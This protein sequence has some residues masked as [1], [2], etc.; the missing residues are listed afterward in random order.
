MHQK[1]NGCIR[2]YLLLIFI[3]EAVRAGEHCRQP[4]REG[5]A[6]GPRTPWGFGEGWTQRQM[7]HI[8]Q[9]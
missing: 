5:E 9:K 6:E 4:G 2:V 3:A 8:K 1:I 7:S